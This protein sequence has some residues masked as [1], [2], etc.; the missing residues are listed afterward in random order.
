MT[1]KEAVQQTRISY[2]RLAQV[3]H[4]SPAALSRLLNDGEYPA[5]REAGE[6][7]NL[8]LALF[9][10]HGLNTDTIEFTRQ[11]V[12]SRAAT[13]EET[14]ELMKLDQ[15]ILSHFRFSSDPFI[16]DVV[17]DKDVFE[18]KGYAKL[19]GAIRSA[20]N[21]H[22]MVALAGPVGS[23]KTTL[24]DGIEQDYLYR[25]DLIIKPYVKDK[26]KLTD[27]HLTRALLYSLK[28]EN[29]RIPSNAEDQGR[30]LSRSLKALRDSENTLTRRAIL[31]I[32]DAHH[33]TA[34]VLRTLKA[35]HEEKAGRH[36]LL[37]IV[38]VGTEELKSKLSR[39]PEIGNRARLLEMPP[40]LVRDYL[41]FKLGRV[42]SKL[43]KV[44]EPAALDAFL[45]MHRTRPGSPATG[46]PL[47]INN[48]CIRVLL[49]MFSTLEVESGMRVPVEIVDKVFGSPRRAA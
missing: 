8:F 34:S 5:R 3:L 40:V 12:T 21:D 30:L 24:M 45:A 46:A 19:E 6:I 29:S 11:A 27:G 16:N 42:G 22:G 20:M 38:L 2:R 25:G 43:D 13:T 23:G 14:E 10:E 7:V 4:L 31:Y 32:D 47:S 1:L 39:S 28:G 35:F 44:F 36:R 17:E 26:E 37:A 18:H 41:D 48:A 9:A 49:K 15:A 33:C